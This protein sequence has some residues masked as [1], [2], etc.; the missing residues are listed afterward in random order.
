MV[1]LAMVSMV[2]LFAACSRAKGE[3][4]ALRVAVPAGPVTLDPRLA[5][6]AVGDKI[7]HLICDGLFKLN[8]KL[9]LVPNLAVR[10]ERLS[11]TSYRFFLRSGVKFH[12]GSEFTAKDVAYTYRSI[13]DGKITSPFSSAFGRIQKISVESPL[14]VRIDLKEPYAPFLTMLTRGIVPRGAAERMGS[15]FATAPVGTGP[16]RFVRFVPGS[17]VEL[18]AN[19]QYAGVI[20]KTQRLVFEVIKDDNI[21]VLKL[22]KGDVDLVQNAV[23]PLLLDRLVSRP[24]LAEKDETGIVMAYMGFNLEDPLLKRRRVR[25][26]IAYA[27][28]RDQIIAHRW[29]G[30]AVKAN[31]ILAPSNWAYDHKLWQYPYDP[32]KAVRLLDE[33]GLADPDGAGPAM[34]FEIALKTSTVKS[35][36]DIVRMIA[37]Q[38]AKVGIGVRVEPYEWGTF[39]KDVRR[40]NFQAYTLSWVGVTDPDIFYDVCHSSQFPP[41]GLNRGRYRNLQVDRLV[42]EGRVTMDRNKRRVIYNKVQRILLEDLPFIPLWYEKNVVVYGRALKGVHLWPNASYRTFVDVEKKEMRKNE[43]GSTK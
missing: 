10:Y 8:R 32:K 39:F 5:S 28:D 9:E 33:E 20:P 6:D 27:I 3:E 17:V 31:S 7:S 4:D 21:R 22:M 19:T 38:L 34:R 41:H 24:N 11:D 14:V 42:E 23:P 30:M 35:R 26:A 29:R 12:D 2:A 40:G 36:I 16:Y 15:T 1:A 37:H 13:I 25:Q 43:V 18:A